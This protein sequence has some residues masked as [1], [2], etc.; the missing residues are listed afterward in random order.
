MVTNGALRLLAEEPFHSDLFS[1]GRAE[2]GELVGVVGLLRQSPCE[3][4]IARRPTQL[5]PLRLNF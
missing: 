2:A 3:G 4:A 5:K 1:V